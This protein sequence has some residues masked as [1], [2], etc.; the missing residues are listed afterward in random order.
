MDFVPLV[1]GKAHEWADITLILFG[2]PIAG[3]TA[4]SYKNK[5]EK[6]NNYG[7]GS[8]PVSRAYGNRVPEAS[9]TLLAEEVAAIEAQAPD[10][11]IT[12]VGP[13]P[14]I[15]AYQPAG[16]LDVVTHTILDAEFTEDGRDVKQ[17]DKKIEVQLPLIISGIKFK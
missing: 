4:I 9:I 14:I 12:R 15:V 16:T 17:G 1:N 7:A 2:S 8:N 11:D 13:F 10:G 6:E 3:I 5:R